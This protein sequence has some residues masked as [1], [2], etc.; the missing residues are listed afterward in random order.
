MVRLYA[1]N[2]FQLGSRLSHWSEDTFPDLL[3]EPSISQN[4]RQDLDLT[5][6]AFKDIGWQLNEIPFPHQ[7]YTTFVNE[8]F[9][10]GASLTSPADN[11]DGD[12]KTNLEEYT[13]G[14]NPLVADSSDNAISLSVLASNSG[15]LTY[16]RN[17]L[18]TDIDFSLGISSDLASFVEAI[19]GTDFL[20]THVQQ[21]SNSVEELTVEVNLSAPQ[22]FYEIGLELDP[23]P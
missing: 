1:P 23:T 4:L 12:D 14:S 3:M 22:S 17:R 2:P 6:T 11:P 10:S 21:L 16:K 20:Q 5:L 9:P 19:S 18:A 8:S 15:L 13:Y 7:S